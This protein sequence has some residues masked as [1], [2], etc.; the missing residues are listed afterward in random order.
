[1][2]EEEYKSIFD[3]NVAI[4]TKRIED[5]RS[6]FETNSSLF[7]VKERP[8]EL[9][10]GKAINILFFD[11]S[12]EKSREQILIRFKEANPNGFD[13]DKYFEVSTSGYSSGRGKKNY[14]INNPWQKF[15][16]EATIAIEGDKCCYIGS[17]LDIAFLEKVT[18]SS[19]LKEELNLNYCPLPNTIRRIEYLCEI[20]DPTTDI[21][22]LYMD[23]TAYE[24]GKENLYLISSDDT[25]F[26]CVV[27][28]FSRM[29]DGGSTTIKFTDPSN[30]EYV[31]S[32]P[33]RLGVPY[34]EQI[35]TL[36][37][38]SSG[39]PP[40]EMT[41]EVPEALRDKI[42]SM[43]GVVIDPDSLKKDKK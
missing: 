37:C 19:K 20:K 35:P 8:P 14:S 21:R 33:N 16:K 39:I 26:P 30:N 5:D 13:T 40:T 43:L 25:A 2:F 28:N 17:T 34:E 29:R 41:R 11:F 7:G 9:F 6:L 18:D 23:R 4:P 42:V 22:Y 38:T 24:Y 10:C 3:L 1:M 36:S 12:Y 32:Y 15:V 27:K 31:F